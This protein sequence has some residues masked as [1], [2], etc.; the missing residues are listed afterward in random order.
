MEG[1]CTTTMGDEKPRCPRLRVP[2]WYSM[3]VLSICTH[4]HEH[5]SIDFRLNISARGCLCLSATGVKLFSSPALSLPGITLSPYL[6]SG[7]HTLIVKLYLRDPRRRRPPY[8]G[9]AQ[10]HQASASQQESYQQVNSAQQQVRSALHMVGW[11][12]HKHCRL[13]HLCINIKC[14]AGR[15]G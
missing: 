15:G 6:C 12:Q 13:T 3:D 7:V 2:R 9:A 14:G 10:A 4:V 8:Q 5:R 1:A 11:L